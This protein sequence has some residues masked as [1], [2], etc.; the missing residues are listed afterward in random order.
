MAPGNLGR[1]IWTCFG[2]MLHCFAW[3]FVYN[4]SWLC[5][6]F[7]F[8]CSSRHYSVRFGFIVAFSNVVNVRSV[9]NSYSRNNDESAAYIYNACDEVFFMIHRLGDM[10]L[11]WCVKSICIT[12][13]HFLLERC[14]D[15][16]EEHI[17]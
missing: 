9:T 10:H 6:A 7:V 15:I 12:K 13:Y 1:D 2:N 8:I 14:Y 16:V 5:T 11:G 17:W 4:A 3:S